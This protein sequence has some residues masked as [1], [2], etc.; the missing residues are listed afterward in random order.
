MEPDNIES[1][2]NALAWEAEAATLKKTADTG[3]LSF[4]S[5]SSFPQF[6]HVKLLTT[7]FD[8]SMARWSSLITIIGYLIASIP[9]PISI[10][11]LISTAVTSPS[12]V[13]IPSLQSLALA[14]SPPDDA[15]KVLACMSALATFTSST[16][17]PSLFA[18]VYIFSVE[19]WAELIF[20]VGALWV[21]LSLVP[22]LLVRVR[23]SRI[24]LVEDHDE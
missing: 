5:T 22:L 23:T 24:T 9:S 3:E 8:L 21:S 15:G 6:A 1:V 2:K 18:A 20:V 7:V 13:V 4:K 12:A 10:N 11:F 14:V 19:R 17:G 16:V